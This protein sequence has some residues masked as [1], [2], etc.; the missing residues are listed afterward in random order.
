MISR[1]KRP[2]R[3]FVVWDKDFQDGYTYANL[4]YSE[5]NRSINTP[6]QKGIGIPIEYVNQDFNLDIQTL[7]QNEMNVV[8]FLIDDNFVY[9]QEFWTPILTDIDNYTVT[10]KLVMPINIDA[11]PF[12]VFKV[13]T[14]KNY[15]TL[16]VT[17]KKEYFQ[18]TMT[19]EISRALNMI[20][21][22]K[23]DIKLFLSHSK[24]TGDTLVRK[25]KNEID[26]NTKLTTFYDN[27]DI[28]HGERF[29][30]VIEDEIQGTIVIGFLT[31]GFSSREWCVKEL[32]LA[33]E[34]SCPII[35]LDFYEEGEKRLFPYIG[36]CRIIRVNPKHIRYY[37]LLTMIMLE[38]IK[39]VYYKLHTEYLIRLL[40]IE[41]ENYSI[42]SSHPELLTVSKH[43]DDGA[44]YVYPEPPVIIDEMELIKRINKKNIY[45]TPL[46]FYMISKYRK[47]N[48][49]SLNVGVSISYE[50]KGKNHIENLKLQDV[51]LNITRYFLACNINIHYAGDPNYNS[52]FSFTNLMN[53]VAEVLH[54][55]FNPNQKLLYM[56]FTPTISK[57]TRKSKVNQISLNSNIIRLDDAGEYD[58]LNELSSVRYKL[59]NNVDAQIFL[60]GALEG[61]EG[62]MPGVI[63][64]YK[65]S[66]KKNNAIFLIGG[67]GGAT[68]RIISLLKNEIALVDIHDYESGIFETGL[69]ELKNGLSDFDNDLLFTSKDSDVI[70]SLI[71]KG[72]SNLRR[73]NK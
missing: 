71:L 55:D 61:Y 24:S 49:H 29:D 47:N 13:F 51:M 62:V 15:V 64:E 37:S 48:L 23:K 10:K 14:S 38:N 36:N 21:N 12:K 59:V 60:G 6:S 20:S 22:E 26:M 66:S 54:K 40:E 32:I 67:F 46:L 16:P 19:Y 3:V 35:L 11:N 53:D 39:I 57:S 42:M 72:L 58:D 27:H 69:G 31:D 33:K 68:K 28:P 73:E 44:I 2:L 25:I 7:E 17:N 41:S 45:V 63:E 43:K 4:L 65:M 52:E 1:I 50:E 8:I 9:N 70:I 56:Y 18:F 34:Y 30:M 5:L